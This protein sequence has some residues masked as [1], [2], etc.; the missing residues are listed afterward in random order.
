MISDFFSTAF[1]SSL[2]VSAIAVL[3]MLFA[4][5]MIF[6]VRAG[7]R[8]QARYKTLEQFSSDLVSEGSDFSIDEARERMANTEAGVLVSQ[9]VGEWTETLVHSRGV[10]SSELRNIMDAEYFFGVDR[11]APELFRNRLLSAAPGFLTA[12]GLISTFLG[13]SLG[14]SGIDLTGSAESL[15]TGVGGLVEGAGV[16]FIPS[17]FGVIFSVLLNVATKG[18]QQWIAQEFASP[19]ELKIDRAVNRVTAEHL[20]NDSLELQR[21]SAQDIKELSEKI[22]SSVGETVAESVQKLSVELRAAI[23]DSLQPALE[24]LTSAI[25]EQ[26]ADVFDTLT[27]RMSEGFAEVGREQARQLHSG[28][29]AID[30]AVSGLT[31]GL[32]QVQ[33]ETTQLQA[34]IREQATTLSNAAEA[35][36]GGAAA[37]DESATKFHGISD[38]IRDLQ[39]VTVTKFEELLEQHTGIFANLQ[40]YM[41]ALPRLQAAMNSTVDG[42]ANASQN[43]TESNAAAVAML[44]RTTKVTVEQ[45]SESIAQQSEHARQTYERLSTE[46]QAAQK[47]MEGWLNEY[48]RVVER[49][50]GE[51]MDTWNQHSST[52]ATHMLSVSQT[53]QGVI[54]EMQDQSEA[55]SISARK[56]EEQSAQLVTSSETIGQTIFSALSDVPALVDVTKQLVT[57]VALQSAPTNPSVPLGQDVNLVESVPSSRAGRRGSSIAEQ[58]V[59]P[60]L[61]GETL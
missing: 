29:E 50:T 25:V 34:T 55:V 43:V 46:L 26:N 40:N 41:L 45:L 5:A 52:Y 4:F 30:A 36:A 14:L 20:L 31:A 8:A 47:Q 18:V 56:T 48:A 37:L 58:Q 49:Q 6:L 1:S 21:D 22:G 10:G 44:E 42:L 16:A 3:F 24:S 51:R 9:V 28:A 23:A 17:L 32:T 15:K 7:T 19:I 54:A 35:I 53:L 12:G 13:L 11:I 61:G 33:D 60:V 59:A 57:A 2:T 39:E 38:Q 27:Q